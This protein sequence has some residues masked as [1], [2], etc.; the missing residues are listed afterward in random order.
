MPLQNRAQLIVQGGQPRPLEENEITIGRAADNRIVLDDPTISAYHAVILQQEGRFIVRDLNSSNGLKVNGTRV[1]EA[2]LASRDQV[3][4]GAVECL[5]QAASEELP[6]TAQ[7][8]P[9][10]DSRSRFKIFLH[11]LFSGPSWICP[12]CGSSNLKTVPAKARISISGDR[13]CR[14]CEASWAPPM[15][16]WAAT[17]MLVLFLT[18][19]GISVTL[20]TRVFY[21]NTAAWSLK[22][23]DSEGTEEDQRFNGWE[24]T[25]AGGA[26]AC[27]PFLL[28]FAGKLKV[29]QRPKNARERIPPSGAK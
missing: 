24:K 18:G 2:P 4:F 27:F 9:V 19:L 8:P 6:Q 1:S 12:F 26:L 7:S 3:K 5:F 11:H 10:R 16:K 17:V 20:R 25:C 28:G 14:G 22:W 15:P 13:I 23:F 21:P 29:H